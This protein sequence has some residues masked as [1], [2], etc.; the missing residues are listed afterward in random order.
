MDVQGHRGCRGYYPENT[1]QG[2]LHAI[3]IG[4]HTLEM[5]AVVSKEGLTIISHEPFMSHEIS[6]TPDGRYISGKDEE[7]HNIYK[8]SYDEIKTYD[9]GS[10]SHPR[11]LDQ[12]KLSTHK[13]SLIDMAKAVK[14]KLVEKGLLSI[15]YNIEIKRKPKWDITEHHPDLKTF[16]DIVIRDIIQAGIMPTTTVQCFDVPTLQYIHETY[17]EVKTVYLVENENTPDQNLDLLGFMPTVYSPDFKLVDEALVLL[18]KHNRMKL[19]P[20]TVNEL[21]DIEHMIALKV[22]GIIS[23]Y[24]NRVINLLKLKNAV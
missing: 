17:P 11:F 23:D 14:R 7:K 9:T 24:P 8:M 10:R 6:M 21:T 16:A 20:W 1:I 3:D 18:C 2:F 19:I 22:D 12:L 15:N 4:V 5:D 13:P